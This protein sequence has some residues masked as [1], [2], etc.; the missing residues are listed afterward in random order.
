MHRVI[1]LTTDFGLSDGF[2]GTLKGVILSINP[3]AVIVDITHEIAP[4]DIEQGAFLF[5]ASARFFP[6]NAVHVVVVDPGV[7]STRRPI[8][9]Q[10][11]EAIFVAPDNGVLSQ[12]VA[13]RRQDDPGASVRAVHLDR[14]EFWL[15]QVSHTFHGRD[16]FVPSAAH[17]SLGIPLSA[18]GTRIEDWIQLASA[19]PIR[20]ED[21]SLLARVRHTDRFGNIVIN[22]RAGEMVGWDLHHTTIHIGGLTLH[23]VQQTY[24][25]VASGELLAL[26]SS[27]GDLEVAARDASAA[28]LLDIHIGD[29]VLVVP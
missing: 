5:A 19:S 11:G 22:I 8:A 3:E 14:P 18:L 16:I 15:P 24:S 25:E 9:I 21:G 20:Q 17:L 23:G 7:G 26:V 13:D 29:R 12:A 6:P 27:N 10:V 2:V 4:Q 28:E 1:S